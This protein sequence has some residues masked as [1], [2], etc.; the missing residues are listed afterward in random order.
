MIILRQKYKIE[1]S[2]SIIDKQWTR[3]FLKLVKMDESKLTAPMLFNGK[4]NQLKMNK[5]VANNRLRGTLSRFSK[6]KNYEKKY[7]NVFSEYK[8][9]GYIIEKPEE[10]EIKNYIPHQ[11]V[12]NPNKDKLRIVLDCS[13]AFQGMFLN[14][15]LATGERN[16]ES[17]VGILTKWLTRRWFIIADIRAMFHQV[18]LQPEDMAYCGNEQKVISNIKE[19]VMTKHV[20]GAIYSMCRVSA[21]NQQRRDLRQ[22]K[23]T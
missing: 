5:V 14:D 1:K 9:K 19:F 17:L 2:T 13:A 6:N 15:A 21:H 8:K 10:L 23:K 11:G 7:D 12:D 22:R 18:W 3:K 4:Q 20:F 16:M